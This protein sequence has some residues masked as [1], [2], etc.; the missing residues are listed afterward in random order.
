M[1]AVPP[2]WE[3]PRRVLGRHGL[4]PK[5]A[6]SQNFL[7]SRGVVD[8]IAR[9]VDPGEGE[10]VVELGPGLGTLTGALLRAGARV[11]AVESDRD[12]L[13]VLRAELGREPRAELVS[14]DAR[15]LDLRAIAA[16]E[17]HPVAVAG[18][19]PYAVTGGILRNLVDQREAVSRAVVMVQ[20]EVRDR[21]LAPPA[22]KTYGALTVFVSA[23]YDVRPV[24][25]V[26]PGSFH[27]PPKVA[28]AVVHLSPWARPRARLDE[29]FRIVVRAVFDARRKT[30]RNALLPAFGDPGALDAA[31]AEVGIEPTIRG[32][33]LDLAALDA[34]A[35]ALRRL[36]A[37]A[38]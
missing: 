1:P 24:L 23:V 20:K 9:A 18:N 19:L 17:G 34:L 26:K 21:L 32:E 13:T 16:R 3:D 10:L 33:R 12:M 30:L 11:R 6:F 29:A 15:A 31:L 27:P 2:E 22:T 8:R 35:D 25:T 7:V 5:R 14:G 37:V 38:G 4:H 36:R 28:S